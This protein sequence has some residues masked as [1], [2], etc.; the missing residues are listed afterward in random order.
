VSTII[1]L[2]HSLELKVVAEGVETEL[3]SSILRTLGCDQAQGFLF[4][5]PLSAEHFEQ[6]LREPDR[7]AVRRAATP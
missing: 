1:H 3:Q 2:A 7:A 4:S 6:Q 5:R